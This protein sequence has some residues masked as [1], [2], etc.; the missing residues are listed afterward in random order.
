L[1]FRQPAPRIAS[2]R[3][4]PKWWKQSTPP[5]SGSPWYSGG[6]SRK[7][8]PPS[9]RRRAI[10]RLE[11][12]VQCQ[13]TVSSKAPPGASTRANSRNA[14]RWSGTCSSTSRH[15][16][17]SSDASPKRSAVASPWRTQVHARCR[18]SHADSFSRFAGEGWNSLPTRPGKRRRRAMNNGLACSVR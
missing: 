12:F 8:T 4:Q 10:S 7:S 14:A 2:S 5:P 3:S 15:R 6:W 13:G 11:A 16:I 1:R 17:A 9:A 18:H